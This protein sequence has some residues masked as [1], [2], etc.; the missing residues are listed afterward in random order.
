MNQT[1]IIFFCII[2][3]FAL[4]AIIVYQQITFRIG[5]QKDLWNA[6]DQLQA[7]LDNDSDEKVMV[8]TAVPAVTALLAQINRLLDARQQV[9]ADYRHTALASKK[10]LSNISHDIKTPITV[11][12][13]YLEILQLQQA[14][15]T[16]M[17]HKVEQQAVKVADLVNQFFSLAKLEAG[18]APLPLSC[19]DLAACCRESVLEF[20]TL[21]TENQFDVVL[22]IPEKPVFVLGNYHGLQRIFSNLISNAI[23]YGSAG[24]YLEVAIRSE[25]NAVFVDIVD[26]GKGIEPQFTQAVFDRLFTLEDSRNRNMQGNG[27]GLAIARNLARQMEGDILLTSQPGI[28][29]TFCVKLKPFL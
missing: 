16:G 12:L 11:I 18:D 14:D 5:L 20:Y 17:L 15:H 1:L 25:E 23:R 29:T 9:S 13:G 7:I 8:F 3:I 21:L 22:H 24:N 6:A 26:K 10:L 19:T 28:R 4:L 27:L 2:G